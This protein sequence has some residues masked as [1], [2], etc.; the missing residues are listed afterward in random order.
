MSD[1]GMLRYTR[2]AFGVSCVPELFQRE[3]ERVLQNF[4]DCCVVFLEDI[5]IFTRT[6]KD[7]LEN[8]KLVEEALGMNN[9]TINEAKTVRN[10]QETEFL[11]FSIKDGSITPTTSKTE[12]IEHFQIP[13][14]TKELRS[15]LGMLN[16]LQSFI[17]NVAEK[18]EL[19]RCILRKKKGNSFWGKEQNEAFQRLKIEIGYHLSPRKMF[20][21]NDETLIYTDN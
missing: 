5:L 11:E 7:L 1:L 4:R 12:A 9:L 8:Q 19:L 16:H 2:L 3:M 15:F 6:E 21:V 18:S 17:P 10:T 13:R 14:T 20:N